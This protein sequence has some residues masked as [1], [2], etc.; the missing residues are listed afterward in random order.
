[1]EIILLDHWGDNHSSITD[2]YDL[3][4]KVKELMPREVKGGLLPF[5]KDDP[6]WEFY[7]KYD[8]EVD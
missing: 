3:N 8:I 7:K 1:M 5:S 2:P 4:E 6:I